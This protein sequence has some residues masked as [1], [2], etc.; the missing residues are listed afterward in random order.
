MSEHKNPWQTLST[1]THYDN[2]WIKVEEHQVINPSGNHGIYGKVS[3]KNQAV[4]I[5][6][7]DRD[8]NIRLVGQFRYPLNQYSWEIP[9][10]G[11]PAGEDILI[12]AKRE[13][14]EETGVTASKW[15]E[16]MRLHLSNSV[17][18]E[19]AIIFLAEDLTEGEAMPE[20]TEE[21]MIRKVPFSEAVQMV[22]AGTITDSMSVAGILKAAYLKLVKRHIDIVYQDEY[23]AVVNKPAGLLVHRIAISNDREFLLQYVRDQ[24]KRTVHPVHRLDRPT[25]GLVIFAFNRDLLAKFTEIFTEHQIKKSYIAIV[26]GYVEEHEI[27]DYPLKNNVHGGS[28]L[29]QAAITEYHKLAEVE[30]PIA[31]GRYA[32]ARYSLVKISLKTG[33]THQIRRHFAHIRHPLIGDTMHGDGVHNRFFRKHFN[34]HRL[35]L[36]ANELSFTHPISGKPVELSIPLDKDFQQVVDAMGLGK[37][38]V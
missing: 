15:R 21:L 4:G 9:E 11:S 3:F 18:D 20:D 7:V 10:G 12:S 8:A 1:K 31:V 38:S 37:I 33:R 34:C 5:I 13:L 16:L 35:L 17:S 28:G 25:S 14:R 23:I 36:M 19:E 22:M 27:I 2:A 32:T 24:L 6:A 29:L 30:L 26:R